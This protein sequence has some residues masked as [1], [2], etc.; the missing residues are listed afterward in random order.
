MV[1]AEVDSVDDSTDID[2]D[3]EK[4]DI[5]SS[6]RIIC[7]IYFPSHCEFETDKGFQICFVTDSH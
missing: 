5:S 2:L 1:L 6:T 3:S 4:T 7:L